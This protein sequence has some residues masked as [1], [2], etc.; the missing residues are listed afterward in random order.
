MNRLILKNG[1]IFD[2]NFERM[3]ADLFLRGNKIQAVGSAF[4][5]DEKTYDVTGC[6]IVPGFVDIHIHGCLG[7]DICDGSRESL[8]HMAKN[9]LTHGVTSF[10]PTTMDG[11]SRANCNGCF[12]CQGMYGQSSRG[13]GCLRSEY[14]G[15]VHLPEEKRRSEGRLCPS[16]RLER[17]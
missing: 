6:L 4:G 5:E 14:G 16:P 10:C 11:I 15:P 13:C 17:V 9:L 12:R 3:K 7:A 8:A 1:E 2:G